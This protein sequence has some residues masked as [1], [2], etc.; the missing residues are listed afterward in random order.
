M[1]CRRTLP[2][3]CGAGCALELEGG[4]DGLDVLPSLEESTLRVKRSLRWALCVFAS[5][6]LGEDLLSLRRGLLPSGEDGGERASYF[7][8]FLDILEFSFV[9]SRTFF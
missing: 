5:V 8:S 6:C 7:S 2:L 1:L 3:R 4:L 9:K